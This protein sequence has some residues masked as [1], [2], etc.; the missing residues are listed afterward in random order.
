LKIRLYLVWQVLLFVYVMGVVVGVL[1]AQ[2]IWA[3]VFWVGLFFGLCL[4]V[5][6]VVVWSFGF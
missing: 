1:C 5:V 3:V 4:V 2:V 6:V